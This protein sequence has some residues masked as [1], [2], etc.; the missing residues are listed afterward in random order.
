VPR[1]HGRAGIAYLGLTSGAA[2]S[3]LAY[4]SDW[5]VTITA[6]R[7][8]LTAVDDPNKVYVSGIPV[9]SGT[10]NGWYD[11][12]TSQSYIAATD[13]LPRNFYLYPQ[14]SNPLQFFAGVVLP[15][16]GAAGGVTAAVSVKASWS[17]EAPLQRFSGTYLEDQLGADITDQAG[18]LMY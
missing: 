6:T 8:A 3:P 2:A 11:T 16:F 4:L 17:A 5:T 13:G 18:G 10:L 1:I 15:D 14:V 7:T 12:G 9:A